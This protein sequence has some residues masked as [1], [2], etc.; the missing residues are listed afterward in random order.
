M[1]A[2]LHSRGASLESRNE[3]GATAL[4]RAA[5]SKNTQLLEWLVAHGCSFS[6]RDNAGYTALLRAAYS[7]RL[8]VL[9]WMIEAGLMAPAYLQHTTVDGR[10]AAEIAM[11]KGHAAFASAVQFI[12]D[13]PLLHMACALRLPRAVRLML[14]QGHL[15]S[16]SSLTVAADSMPFVGATRPCP[17]TLSL[18]TQALQPWAPSR[19]YL[20][21]PTFRWSVHQLLMIVRRLA[22]SSHLP[23]LPPE[24]WLYIIEFF[25]RPLPLHSPTTNVSAIVT[26]EITEVGDTASSAAAAPLPVLFPAVCHDL[27]LL[28]LQPS[29]RSE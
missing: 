2:Y 13:Q 25:S 7:G 29:T 26:A 5:R 10:R 21:G 11:E 14:S 9:T 6:E 24:L 27:Q 8:H 15:P 23:L 12:S 18:M 19:H 28:P 1:V 22:T 3:N 16:H 4:L 20:Y 17:V